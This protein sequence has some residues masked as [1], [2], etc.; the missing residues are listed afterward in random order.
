V[1]EWVDSCSQVWESASVG[2]QAAIWVAFTLV[3][4]L[5]LMWWTWRIAGL[6]VLQSIRIVAAAL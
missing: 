5:P 4:S 6:F 2:E 3:V 1:L